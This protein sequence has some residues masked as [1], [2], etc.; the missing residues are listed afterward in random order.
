[1]SVF[2]GMKNV[3][4]VCVDEDSVFSQSKLGSSLS[5]GY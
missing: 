5:K 2:F 1:M 4:R 3:G